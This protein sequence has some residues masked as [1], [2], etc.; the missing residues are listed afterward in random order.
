MVN[1]QKVWTS[2]AQFADWGLCLARTTPLDQAPKHK[3]ISALV[4]DMRADGVDVRPLVQ[5][6]VK[7]SS[8]RSSSTTCSCP[9]TK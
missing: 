5:S 2:Y 7:P 1:G 9:T 8:T 6:T 3:G 4:I